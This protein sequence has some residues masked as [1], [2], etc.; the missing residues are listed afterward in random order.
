V[1]LVESMEE[2]LLG[3]L[4]AADELDVVYQQDINI[5]ELA[6]ELFGAPPPDGADELVGEL[7]GADVEG[8]EVVGAGGVVDGVQQVGL[9]QPHPAV[10]EE[11]VIA[12]TGV[13]GGAQRGGV[14][15]AVAVADDEGV[16]GVAGLALGPY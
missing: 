10:E 8:A 14:G 16:E 13:F 12:L 2:A 15:Q 1:Q 9:A 3:L 4:L 5:A 7:L 6:A 11:G